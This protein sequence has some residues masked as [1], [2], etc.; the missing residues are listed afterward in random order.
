VGRSLNSVQINVTDCYTVLV[1]RFLSDPIIGIIFMFFFLKFQ[2]TKWNSMMHSMIPPPT[3]AMYLPY[4]EYLLRTTPMTITITAMKTT[5]VEIKF[6]II[7]F[8]ILAFMISLL[9]YGS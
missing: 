2:G 7:H 3:H 1:G 6:S 9:A 4:S 8:S 5:I